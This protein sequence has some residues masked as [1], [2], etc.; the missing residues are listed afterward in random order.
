MSTKINAYP[1]DP[2]KIL[3]A[4]GVVVAD[5]LW[6]ESVVLNALIV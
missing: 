3:V 2:N 1:S 6:T 5:W 4:N